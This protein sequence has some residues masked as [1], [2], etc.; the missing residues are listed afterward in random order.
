MGLLWGRKA[1]EDAP[2]HH[3]MHHEHG[4]DHVH[5]H[6]TMDW[7]QIL[8]RGDSIARMAYLGLG[9]N[10]FLCVLKGFAGLALDSSSLMAEASHSASDTI[11]DFATLLCLHKAKQKPTEKYPF[12]YAKM[13]TIGSLFISVTLLAGSLGIGMH[14]F[15]RISDTVPSTAL[16]SHQ[17]HSFISGISSG[18]SHTHKHKSTDPLALA[19]VLLNIIGKEILFRI[20]MA[21]AKETRSSVLAASAQHQRVESMGSI[22]TF[23]A[24]TGTWLGAAWLDPLGGMVQA[25][26][27]FREAWRLLMSAVNHL[28]DGSAGP[29]HVQSVRVQL[30]QLLDYMKER[31]EGPMFSWSQLAVIPNGPFMTAYITLTFPPHTALEQVLTI[32]A[33]IEKRLQAHIPMVCMFES[34]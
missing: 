5:L 3:H 17:I 24:I 8:E 29:E 33:M 19:F 7:S 22:M 2:H 23:L 25:V 9:V 32:E 15:A 30:D 13:E 4:H 21:K 27:N 18:H 26:Y 6:G 10:F 12:G 34:L 1:Q 16:W 31:G 11:S 14:A 20:T 28:C